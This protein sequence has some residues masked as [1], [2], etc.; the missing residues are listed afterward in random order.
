M[1]KIMERIIA[2]KR[3]T[4]KIEEI[5]IDVVA[6]LEGIKACVVHNFLKLYL[7]P[8]VVQEH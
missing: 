2:I 7:S 3:I 5:V 8:A 1:N 4:I 6:V